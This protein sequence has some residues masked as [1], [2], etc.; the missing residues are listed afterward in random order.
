MRGGRATCSGRSAALIAWMLFL[1]EHNEGVKGGFCLL[2]AVHLDEAE[3][4]R[5]SRVPVHDDHQAAV[6][7]CPAQT[8]ATDRRSPSM[9]C[10]HEKNVA[11]AASNHTSR[12]T[13]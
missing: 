1:F 12:L 6:E 10:Y 2:T 7:E 11:A 4:F 13:G 9:E 5:A 3:P 8:A